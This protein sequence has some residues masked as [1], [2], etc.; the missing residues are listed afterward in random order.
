MRPLLEHVQLR[1]SLRGGTMSLPLLALR[2]GVHCR[3][4]GSA[5]PP[6]PSHTNVEELGWSKRPEPPTTHTNLVEELGWSKRPE[7]PTT[8][9]N[10]VEEL[11]W[12]KRPEPP[13]THTNLVE[14]LGWSKRPWAGILMMPASISEMMARDLTLRPGYSAFICRHC[15]HPIWLAVGDDTNRARRI[16][17]HLQ[18]CEERPY[19]LQPL[20]SARKRPVQAKLCQSILYGPDL[21]I[22]YDELGNL[23]SQP[24]RKARRGKAKSVY[25]A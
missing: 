12:S 20:R 14:E 7:P 24:W 21:H 2:P 5:E 22:E 6:A 4:T 23:A 9:T 8:H 11:G 10:L 15:E 18:R 16:N 1:W 3:F 19:H 13:T 25:G 17:F